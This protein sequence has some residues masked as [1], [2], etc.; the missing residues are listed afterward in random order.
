MWLCFFSFFLPLT[1]CGHNDLAKRPNCRWTCSLYTVWL[2]SPPRDCLT[3]SPH[4]P[5]ISA[6]QIKSILHK[7]FL[8]PWHCIWIEYKSD[9]PDFHYSGAELNHTAY[10]RMK[11]VLTNLRNKLLALAQQ[12]IFCFKC[13]FWPVASVLHMFVDPLTGSW[14]SACQ[15]NCDTHAYWRPWY[16]YHYSMEWE[17]I[18]NGVH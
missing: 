1:I 11:Y 3:D 9:I 7:K 6:V 16:T 5:R 12:P 14:G 13:I 10:S 18:T 8:S 2:A 4:L 17:C 15:S